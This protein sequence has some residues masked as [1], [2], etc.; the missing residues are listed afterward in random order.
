MLKL[1][2]QVEYGPNFHIPCLMWA[3]IASNK[4]T[5]FMPHSRARNLAMAVFSKWV[6]TRYSNRVLAAT[7]LIRIVFVCCY[8]IQVFPHLI[9]ISGNQELPWLTFASYSKQLIWCQQTYSLYM[10][11]LWWIAICRDCNSII[12][13]PITR[14]KQFSSCQNSVGIS[15]MGPF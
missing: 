15:G 13:P 7:V 10:S 3:W 9:A 6:S 11:C 8:V 4:Y 14:M 2:N 5:K 12:I 1:L